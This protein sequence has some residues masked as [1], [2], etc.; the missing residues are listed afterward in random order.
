MSADMRNRFYIVG[1]DPKFGTGGASLIVDAY[2]HFI[3][4]NFPGC[5]LESFYL[6]QASLKPKLFRYKNVYILFFLIFKLIRGNSSSLLWWHSFSFF[7]SFLLLFVSSVSRLLRLKVHIVV[8]LHLPRYMHVDSA[9]EKIYYNNVLSSAATIHFLTPCHYNSWQSKAFRSLP[10][11]ID[12]NPLPIHLSRPLQSPTKM[13]LRNRSANRTMRIFSMC[14]LISVK[15]ID[16]VIKAL[17]HLP[18]NY[19]LDIAGRGSEESALRA[20]VY[21]LNLSSRVN[22]LGFVQD[23]EKLMHFSRADIFCVPSLSDTQ[24]IVNVEAILNY[25]PVYLYHYE[26]FRD[27]YGS[28]GTVIFVEPSPEA[29]ASAIKETIHHISFQD[30][31]ESAEIL[32]SSIFSN[33]NL[34]TSI[35]SV[36]K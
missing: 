29:L 28:L 36:L 9:F 17:T 7:D 27:I 3:R 21:S 34:K 5:S 11:I 24:S 10:H 22:F 23:H 35:S 25:T 20:L 8:T 19:T 32:R 30:L 14:Q 33:A 6:H 31:K 2:L 13:P 4:E 1:S 26:P 15:N 12:V 18:P 16:H